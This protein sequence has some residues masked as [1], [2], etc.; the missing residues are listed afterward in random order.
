M[1][2]KEMLR[3]EV[4]CRKCHKFDSC[5]IEDFQKCGLFPL[6]ITNLF[7]NKTQNIKFI[8]FKEVQKI[9]TEFGK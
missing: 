7:K 4:V 5:N 1:I 9:I 8:K 2:V 6:A 3:K